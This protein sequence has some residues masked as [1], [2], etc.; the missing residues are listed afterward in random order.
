VFCFV[1]VIATS[2]HGHTHHPRYRGAGRGAEATA[3]SGGQTARFGD[4][5]GQTWFGQLQTRF[6]DVPID[7][8]R[9]IHTSEFLDAA[10]SLPS[11]LGL[12]GQ[13]GFYPART[14]AQANIQK[15]QN[16]YNFAQAD[17]ETLQSLVR[18]EKKDG[19]AYSGSAA[20]ALLWLTRTLDFTAKAL[21]KDLN[22]NKNVSPDNPNPRKPLSDA[23]Q[24]TYADTLERYHGSWQKMLFG[25]AWT[26]VPRRPD[27]YRRLAAGDSTQAAVDD[28]EKW[29]SALEDIV[30]TLRYFAVGPD[31]HW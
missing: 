5:Y 16:R 6:D 22:D 4:V 25:A 28:T 3:A 7:G 11:F 14:D 31:A 2:E 23:F 30:T 19:V 21:R 9:G 20:E 15:I 26:M 13:V 8:N 12:L 29:V 27:F 10:G 18:K 17:S 1:G 24:K